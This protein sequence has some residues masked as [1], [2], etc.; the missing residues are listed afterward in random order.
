MENIE[1]F[2]KKDELKNLLR[3][4]DFIDFISYHEDKWLQNSEIK[5]KLNTIFGSVEAALFLFKNDEIFN[6]KNF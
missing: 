4:E 5:D 3:N 2:G 1:N 6:S